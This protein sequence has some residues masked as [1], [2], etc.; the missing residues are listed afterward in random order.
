MTMT[1]RD[2]ASDTAPE[3]CYFAGW[4]HLAYMLGYDGLT[5]N[6]R[7]AVMRAVGELVDKGLIKR[8]YVEG[9]DRRKAVY[10]LTW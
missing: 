5:P 4:E 7:K 10:R 9:Y 6:G 3:R 2:A 1:A 8:D